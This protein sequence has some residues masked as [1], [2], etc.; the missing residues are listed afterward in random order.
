L[1]NWCKFFLVIGIILLAG[2]YSLPTHILNVEKKLEFGSS[3]AKNNFSQVKPQATTLLKKAKRV[4]I[5]AP[6][7]CSDE[8]ARADQQGQGGRRDLAEHC[9]VIMSSIERQLFK[10][11]FDVV[12]WQS[13]QGMSTIDLILEVNELS[14]KDYGGAEGVKLNASFATRTDSGS[15]PIQLLSDS[16]AVKRCS[17]IINS[18]KNSGS[19]ALPTATIN[20][21]LV[22]PSDGAVVWFFQH[23]AVENTSEKTTSKF[24]QEYKNQHLEG[25]MTATSLGIAGLISAAIGGIL[26]REGDIDGDPKEVIQLISGGTSLLVGSIMGIQG[27]SGDDHKNNLASPDVVLCNPRYRSLLLSQSEFETSNTSV[28]TNLTA[29]SNSKLEKG[30][31]GEVARRRVRQRVI[32]IMIKTISDI[33][34]GAHKSNN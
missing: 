12:S 25:S 33:R 15:Q 7:T 13:A 31:E 16:P 18:L 5:K 8:S 30:N 2:C 32:D 34:N 17:T 22:R 23:T 10:L 3:L 21:K 6:S 26:I 20:T 24:I 4:A 29:N 9:G 1:S 27:L 19:V 14:T 11:G 28:V